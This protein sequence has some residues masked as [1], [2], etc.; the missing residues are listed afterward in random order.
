MLSTLATIG[1]V[2]TIG[3]ALT[4]S[5]LLG[6]RDERRSLLGRASLAITAHAR[7]QTL[8]LRRIGVRPTTPAR[9]WTEPERGRPLNDLGA[10]STGS[11]SWRM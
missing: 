5:Y 4:L 8:A 6:R 11:A 9:Q 10:P 3:L 2:L 1:I 7:A